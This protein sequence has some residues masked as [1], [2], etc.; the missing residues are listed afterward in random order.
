[1]FVAH[2]EVAI[3]DGCSIVDIDESEQKRGVLVWFPRTDT[4][5]GC[6][7]WMRVAEITARR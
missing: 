1:M 5:M 3:V 7:Q 6:Q 4:H 2:T